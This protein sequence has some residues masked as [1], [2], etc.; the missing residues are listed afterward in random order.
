[1]SSD[2]DA[3]QT[4]STTDGS[5]D[6]LQISRKLTERKRMCNSIDNLVHG[7]TQDKANSFARLPDKMFIPSSI[8]AQ[9]FTGLDYKVRRYIAFI[10][11]NDVLSN[12]SISI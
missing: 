10:D 3:I 7:R 5:D 6:D 2:D 1:M 9:P 12:G 11:D 8:I 4:L